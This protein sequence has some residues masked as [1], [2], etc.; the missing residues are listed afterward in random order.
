[1]LWDP[2]LRESWWILIGVA[3]PIIGTVAYVLLYLQSRYEE[4]RKRKDGTPR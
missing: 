1:M 4:R 3:I 2:P